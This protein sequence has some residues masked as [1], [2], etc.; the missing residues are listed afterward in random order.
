MSPAGHA[1]LRHTENVCI[2][3]TRCRCLI[4]NLLTKVFFIAVALTHAENVS[5]ASE[6]FTYSDSFTAWRRQAVKLCGV[7]GDLWGAALVWL[8]P[9][10]SGAACQ[11]RCKKPQESFWQHWWVCRAGPVCL[12]AFFSH[13]KSH[14]HI[15]TSVC[16]FTG[17][18]NLIF[19]ANKN[20]C[21]FQLTQKKKV[22]GTDFSTFHTT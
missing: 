9:R 2:W 22:T 8:L 4:A 13:Y 14:W 20:W 12:P 17:W 6:N 19:E 18:M 5:S 1:I 21:R 10:Q 11:L 15:L 3:W 7:S 16:T